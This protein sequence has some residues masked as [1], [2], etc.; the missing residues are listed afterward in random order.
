MPKVSVVVPTYNREEYICETIDSILAQTFTDFEVV[1]VDDGSKDNT[2]AKLEQYGNKIKVVRQPNS[3]RAVARNN[4]VQN[5]TGDLIAFVDSDDVWIKDK[6]EK[7]VEVLD[8]NPDVICSNGLC[9]RIDENSN[10][11]QTAK[12]QTVGHSGDVFEELLFRNFIVSPTPVVRRAYF[13]KSGGFETKYIPY[14]DW[15]LWLKV[16]TLG[17][18]HYLNRPLAYY[19]VHSEQ[20]VQLV[21][22]ERIEEVT[23][24][25]LE[26]SYKLKDIPEEIIN[27]SRGLANLRFCY[28]YLLS[29][30]Y[31]IAK[32]KVQ[33]A[34]SLY[35]KFKY[36]P[37]WVGLNMI[38]RFPV[39]KTVAKL[40][41]FHATW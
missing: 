28:W 3:E 20:S 2:L 36:D 1:I 7:Q 15:Q 39:L 10:K 11:I 18:F 27:K 35:P 19:R 25:L 24:M 26:D 13:E 29:G 16:S 33:E 23:T 5:S 37:K 22:S 12:R 17:K 30:D 41:K 38:A 14:E 6:L 21:K 40:D 32:K 34:V 8:N 4:G 9:L 31:D